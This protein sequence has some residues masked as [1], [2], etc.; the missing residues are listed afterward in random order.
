[1][2]YLDITGDAGVLDECVGFFDSRGVAAGERASVWEHIQRALALLERR[3]IPGTSLA[4]YGNG[5]WNDSLQ[6]A[7]P[8]MRDHLCSS[9]TVT[10]QYKV[11][12]ELAQALRS[13][14]RAADA[15][16]LELLAQSVQRDF[17]DLL[18]VDR[19]LAG[20]ALFDA[21][22]KVRHLLHPRDLTTGVRY[23]SLAMIHAILENLFTPDQAREHMLLI[24]AEL[25]APDGV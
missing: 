19:V 5:D 15:P 25:C 24:E 17:R 4:A 22:G 12:R 13:I 8:A 23:S 2:Q 20:Y 6:P 21:D 9:W 14:G 7:D 11:L 10:L 3:T 18:L 16:R 1:V